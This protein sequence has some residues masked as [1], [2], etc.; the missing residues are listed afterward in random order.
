[1][2]G[3]GK[4]FFIVLVIILLVSTILAPILTFSYLTNSY[5]SVIDTHINK[6][7][8]LQQQV[9]YLTEKNNQLNAENAQLTNL[10]QPYLVTSI[11]WYVHKSND[12][13]SSS[14]NTFTIYGKIYN[15]GHLPANNAEIT[16]RFYGSNQTLLQTSTVHL[17]IIYSITNS[18]IPFDIGK[19]D[20]D[21]S[22]A[23]SV[24]DVELYLNYQ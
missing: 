23:D 10:S 1:M 15:I 22:V 3:F 4:R 14:R 16:V 18:T 21:C 19:R 17:G 13:V 11:G 8:D 20:I 2:I 9:D 12:P 5:N 24:T 7:K 6:E